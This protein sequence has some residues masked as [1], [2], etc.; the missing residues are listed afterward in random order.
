MIK[1][2]TE[3]VISFS[4]VPLRLAG[5]FGL[6]VSGVSFVLGI[7][8]LIRWFVWG[9]PVPGYTSIIVSIF[10]LGGVIL[11]VLW[12][13]GLYVSRIHVQVKKRPI[14]VIRDMIE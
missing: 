11:I 7:Y 1:L 5:Y 12:V 6:V 3:G 14:Y 10:F 13:I 4:D 2:A 8:M 9:I